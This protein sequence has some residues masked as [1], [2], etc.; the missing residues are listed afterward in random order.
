MAKKR[1]RNWTRIGRLIDFRTGNGGGLVGLLDHLLECGEVDVL[2][3]VEVETRLAD[4]VLA[5]FLQQG[6]LLL[7][8]AVQ[9]EH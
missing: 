3:L 8:L 6:G 5:Q 1:S 4:L 9:V 2:E 7:Q